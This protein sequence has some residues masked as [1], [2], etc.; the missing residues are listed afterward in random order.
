MLLHSQTSAHDFEIRLY[1]W[2]KLK[3]MVTDVHAL[4]A[5]NYVASK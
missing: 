3:R 2:L 1:V 4:W 5:A